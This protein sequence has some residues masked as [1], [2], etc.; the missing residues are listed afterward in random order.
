MVSEAVTTKNPMLKAS[1]KKDDPG[2]QQLLFR[3]LLDLYNQGKFQATLAFGNQLIKG[4]PNLAMLHNILGA[5]CS[6][7]NKMQEAIS[8]MAQAIQLDPQNANFHNN[9]GI[10]LCQAKEYKKAQINLEKA[11][12][13]NPAYAEAYNNLGNV[14]MEKN[15]IK[16]ARY[17]FEK[18]IAYNN[19]YAEAYNNLGILYTESKDYDKACKNFYLAINKNPKLVQVYSNLGAALSY[20]GNYMRAINFFEKAISLD[21][22]FDNAQINLFEVLVN[23]DH[24]KAISQLKKYLTFNT[25]SFLGN[26]ILGQVYE[27]KGSLSS[28][29]KYYQSAID[30]NSEYLPS[31]NNLGLLHS[32]MEEHEKAIQL[33]KKGI[34][35]CKNSKV[36][37][38]AQAN[39]YKNAG[40]LFSINSE[41]NLA[42]LCFD[43][44]LEI[45]P[46]CDESLSEKLFLESATS[47]WHELNK[48]RSDFKK[49]GVT[50]SAISPFMVLGLEDHLKR[51]QIRASKYALEN[52]NVDPLP[53]PARPK[54]PGGKIR[55]G[56]FSADFQD[57]PV[58]HQIA[59]VLALHDR[60]KI[61]VYAYSFRQADDEMRTKIVASVDHF[62]D[63][64]TMTDKDVALLARQDHIDIA[65]DLM[66]YTRGSRSN[67]FAF[68]A[69]PVQI[70]LFGGH[71]GASFI[72]YI[73]A[74]PTVIPDHLRDHY[75]EKIIYLPH[76]YMPTD[77]SREISTRPMTRI[78]MGL[79]ENGFVFCCFNANYKISPREFDIWMRLLHKVEGSVL[80][81]KESNQ[82][83]KSNLQK[84]AV[85]RGIDPTRLIF[86]TKVSAE[87]H[88]ARHQLADLF[89]DTFNFNA[90]STAC[91]A[92]WAGLPLL[93]RQGEQFDARC[94]ASFLNAL[95]LPELII[96]TDEE[97]EERALKLATD[98]D[99]LHSITE[100][101]KLHRDTKPLFDTL[102]YT[103]YLEKGFEKALNSH[104]K[105]K[106]LEDIWIR[107]N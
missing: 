74:D 23:I 83:A 93:T 101:L 36:R 72:D 48:Y 1:Q 94:A 13:I 68:R 58:A 88:L 71:I 56:Y 3:K 18:A 43:A 29:K 4:Y 60:N 21:P 52:Y 2:K 97:Y 32:K 9:L 44:V 107:M 49:I 42:K 91:D 25:Q 73:I 31:L 22:N 37:T 33:Y 98:K 69:A 96:S 106:P 99:L 17:N 11:I 10:V 47:N 30:S 75:Q 103:Q 19:Q 55:I 100:K 82:W 46:N 105:S 51:Q 86:A 20:Q 53:L 24:N 67:I 7:L 28:A 90:H 80:W 14:F 65:I 104:E 78:E 89:L 50:N 84:E 15:Y 70:A 95:E 85:R 26:H 6:N 87:D 34:Q 41:F 61:E 62:K 57:H 92:L 59:K 81:L 16:K 12:T 45:N 8:H 79:P 40:K 63:V 64:T 77:N 54:S 5:T 39:F 27:Q 66:G 38:I 76:S 102:T 35:I